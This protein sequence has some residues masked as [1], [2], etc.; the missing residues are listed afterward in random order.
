MNA[1]LSTSGCLTSSA[2][3]ATVARDDVDD[4]GRHLR[5]AEDVGEEERGERGGLGRLQD[6]RVS[7][8]QSRRDLP[9]QHEHREVPR[10]DLRGDAERPRLSV[11]ERVLELVGPARVVEEVRRGEGKI[12][13]PRLADWLAAVERLEHRELASALLQDAGDPVDD[14]GPLPRRPGRPAVLERSAGSDYRRVHVLGAGVGDLGE[15]LLAGG[16]DG[17]VELTGARLDELT[18]DEEAVPILELNDVPRLGRRG[19]LERG[20]DRRA[21]LLL[22]DLSQA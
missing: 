9:G 10:D 6:D 13:V 3:G 18:A 1:T 4:A 11:R 16:A 21:I 14:L 2:P 8:S 17:G 22:V 7:R 15:L 5:L 12:D 19:V 20:R